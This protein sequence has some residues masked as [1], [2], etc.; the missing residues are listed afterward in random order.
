MIDILKKIQIM[1]LDLLKK[2]R[3][4]NKN[5][6]K[7]KINN[8]NPYANVGYN[9][10]NAFG[11][12]FPANIATNRGSWAQMRRGPYDKLSGA[13]IPGIGFGPNTQVQSLDV[14]KSGM[15][16]RPKKY[17]INY[18]NQQM[19]P[20]KQNLIT[21]PGQ[22]ATPGTQS[23]GAGKTFSNTEGLGAGATG[24]IRRGER[25]TAKE[26]ARGEEQNLSASDAN[27]D[28]Y[29]GFPLDHPIR[30]EEKITN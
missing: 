27:L 16:G 9:G 22:G 10:F 19:D 21:L 12:L 26:L 29:A 25:R 14:T 1:K 30:D 7:S 13:N 2:K 20:R 28:P 23:T 3:N 4:G 11:S 15:F 5:I 8:Q 18:G 17:T 24:A 6:C